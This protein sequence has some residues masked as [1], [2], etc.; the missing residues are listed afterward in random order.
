MNIT[1]DVVAG[2]AGIVL[3]LVLNYIPGLNAKFAAQSSQYKS[4]IVALCLLGITGLVVASS[5]ANL[6]VYLTCDKPGFMKAAEI[7]MSA[8][9]TSQGAYK[10]LPETKGVQ[11]AKA[12]RA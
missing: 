12:A 3:A 5:C 11:E 6:W 4:G 1:A 8:L 2:M 9:V 7:F 10:L